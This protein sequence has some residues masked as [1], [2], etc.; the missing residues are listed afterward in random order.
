MSDYSVTKNRMVDGGDEW[1]V[2]GTLKVGA[3]GTVTVEAG[4]TVTGLTGAT[5]FA[6]DAEAKAG[7]V[8]NKVI[9]PS[10]LKA[11]LNDKLAGAPWNAVITVGEEAA[12]KI[13]VA[14]Q[15]KDVAGADLAVR[16]GVKAYL[17][18]DANGD[19]IIA[20]APSGGIAIGTDGLAIPIVAGKYIDLVSES[21]GDID[22][23]ITEEGAKTCYLIVVLPN[24][25][26]VASGAIAFTA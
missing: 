4:A 10:S 18:D 25:K 1:D 2:D 7:T 13:N 5:T 23:D 17:S 26:L 3:S 19:S 16:G 15:L 12:N 24:G 21:D 9:A 8:T 22:I 20:T 14:L 11:A 6:S